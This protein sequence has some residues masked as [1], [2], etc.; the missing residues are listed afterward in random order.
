MKITA[1]QQLFLFIV[2]T[3][4]NLATAASGEVDTAVTGSV[5]NVTADLAV[6]G[7]TKQEEDAITTEDVGNA[8]EDGLDSA[9]AAAGDVAETVENTSVDV[10]V[11]AGSSTR[12]LAGSTAAVILGAEGLML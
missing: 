12:F 5:V 7:L 9:S 6:E 11:S 3:L 2:A 1:V 8:I 4:S 10:E